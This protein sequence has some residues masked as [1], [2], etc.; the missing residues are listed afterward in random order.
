[1]GMQVDQVFAETERRT[2]RLLAV[3]RLLVL[4]ALAFVF[5]LAGGWKVFWLFS[6][7]ERGQA[8]MVP[9]VGLTATTVVGLAIAQTRFFRPWV[10][11]LLVTLDVAFLIHC[12]VMLAMATG[13]P[14]QLTLETPAASIIF[15]FLATGAVRHRPYLVLYSGGLFVAGWVATWMLAPGAGPQLP[16]ALATDLAHLAVVG[17]V[18]VALFIAVTRARST[19]VKSITEARL[20]ANLSRYFS[21]QVVDRLAQAGDA[22]RA[23]RS[24]KAAILFADLRGFTALTEK[25]PPEE[26]AVF[27]NEYRRRITEP[28]TSHHGM[29]DK[30][31]GDGVMAVFGVPQPG[32]DDAR[33]AMLAGAG[34]LSAIADWSRERTAQ[35]LP[36]VRVGI[37]IHHGDVIAGALGDENRLEYTVIGDAVN[38]AARIEAEAG[39]L[40]ASL[41]ISAE[42]VAAA[43]GM[44]GE[45]H[46]VGLS[47]RLLRGR[48]QP[49]RLYRP[50][51]DM[52]KEHEDP[53]P[54]EALLPGQPAPGGTRGSS[55]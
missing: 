45:L 40:G 6:G 43:P 30:F 7:W 5:W 17:L 31:I 3:L 35:G 22:A 33:D 34:A 49:V 15:V 29:I 11:W 42:A 37:G 50:K 28:I 52:V 8:T 53:M 20:R 4:L 54:L 10:Q 27:L 47:P 18:A 38:T 36:P 24:Q 12:L 44:D 41:L 1:M 46:L 2:E 39:R 14:L 16:Q 25:M 9:R 19:L 51:S 23:F 21:P 48:S 32:P 55:A 26:V 13:Q